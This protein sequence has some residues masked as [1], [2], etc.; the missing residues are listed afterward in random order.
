MGKSYPLNRRSGNDRRREDLGPSPGE[1][2]R[3]KFPERRYPEIEHID[4]DEYVKAL[5]ASNGQPALAHSPAAGDPLVAVTNDL[6]VA[7]NAERIRVYFSDDILH[8]DA[9]GPFDLAAMKTL[10]QLRL[11]AIAKW[12]P[13]PPF[14]HLLTIHHSARM[15]QE[16]FEHYKADRESV[17]GKQLAPPCA[18]ALVITP[19]VE[20]WS[21]MERKILPLYEADGVPCRVFGD[22]ETACLWLSWEVASAQSGQTV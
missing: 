8:I 15:S 16:S 13:Q 7:P 3:R 11:Q 18:H 1:E 17:Y 2:E 10:G 20:G 14:G 4:F 12:N 9:Y 21:D 22:E 19:A 6:P 5:P